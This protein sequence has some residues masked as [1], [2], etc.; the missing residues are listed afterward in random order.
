MALQLWMIS[1][2]LI[3]EQGTVMLPVSQ[4]HASGTDV[5][6]ISVMV[7]ITM[8]HGSKLFYHIRLLSNPGPLDPAVA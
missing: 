4:A 8:P 7:I 1:S 3:W 2:G 6:A 5:E